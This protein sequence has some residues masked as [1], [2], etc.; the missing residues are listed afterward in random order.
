M[1]T[2]TAVRRLTLLV[3]LAGLGAVAA[4]PFTLDVALQRALDRS[5]TILTA[6]NS[7]EISRR[8]LLAQRAALRS[9]F[10]LTLTPL[11]L[12]RDRVF[13]DLVSSYNTQEQTQ[14][15]GLLSI[16]QP[17]EWSDGT[18]SLNQSVNWR[19][20][21]SSF[22]GTGKQST[23]S[24]SLQLRYSQ[25]LF[26]YNRTRLH[27][28]QLELDLENA[29][30]GYAVQR[31]QIESDVTRQYLDLYYRQRNVGISAEELRN[32]TESLGII[33]SKVDAGITAAEEYYQADL[34]RANS[35]ATLENVQMQYANARDNFCLL[36]G[37][38][39]DF[40][41]EVDADVRPQTVHVDLA[42]AV[43]HGVHHRMEVRQS[44]LA[45]RNS[46][47]EVVRTQALNEFKGSVDVSFGLI[48]TDEG[49]A[50]VYSS[51]TR[52]QGVS[53][54]LNV[55]LFDWGESMHRVAAAREQVARSERSAVEQRRRITAEIRQAHRALINQEAQIDI[56][57]KSVDNA[58]RTYEI[59]LERYR[60][61]DL[62]SKDIAFY[63][64]QL[65]REQLSEVFARINYELALLDLKVRT[66]YDFS[67]GE[68]L[69][70]AV[71]GD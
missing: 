42:E 3:A 43:D 51:T 6:R 55:P 39:F 11:Q 70:P 26:T 71:D 8:N 12:S 58:R 28:Q 49:V 31:L 64:T 60:N 4:E 66:L 13:N 52:N 23:Y 9:Q 35:Q 68:P 45:V 25:P 40:E 47:A 32:A 22:A 14:A 59:N 41:F 63:Q 2:A 57:T 44:D 62:S 53:V 38:P 17:I 18:L 65:S 15:G 33:Q 5:P 61:G 27:L 54:Q 48:G 36:L 50:D 34:T 1:T 20:A 56:A 30:L 29:R 21:S 67:R 24:S 7:L 37:L 10:F 46:M 16:R 19:E 69:A